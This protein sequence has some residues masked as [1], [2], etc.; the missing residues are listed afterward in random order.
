MRFYNTILIFVIL[1][2]LYIHTKRVQLT[3]SLFYYYNELPPHFK[4]NTL[5]NKKNLSKVPKRGD[6]KIFDLINDLPDFLYT[7]KI[8]GLFSPRNLQLEWFSS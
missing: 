6:F 4:I 1:I 3:L 2:I 5:L 8:Y 7:F